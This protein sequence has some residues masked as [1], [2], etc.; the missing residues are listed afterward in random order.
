MGTPE[1][2][3]SESKQEYLEAQLENAR[4]K[5]AA[6]A[7]DKICDECGMPKQEDRSYCEDCSA[8]VILE[9]Y[10]TYEIY[11]GPAPH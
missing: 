7:D 6:E 11:Q 8:R 4:A 3:G 1:D 10:D 5:E 9:Q 2:W